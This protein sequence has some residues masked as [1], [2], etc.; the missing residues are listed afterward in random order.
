M[1]KLK[2]NPTLEQLQG[3][4]GGIVFRQTP[5]GRTF[6]SHKPDMSNVVWAPA[7][8]ANRAR[9][10]AAIAYAHAAM[11]DPRVRAIYEQEAAAQ[12]RRPFYLAV[13]DYLKGHNRLAG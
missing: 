7:Q 2:F 10:K 1:T 8:I 6:I 11:R 9:F 12:G 5:A 13:S 3:A 4:F